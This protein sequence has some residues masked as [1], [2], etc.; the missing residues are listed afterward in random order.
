MNF[1]THKITLILTIIR[2]S[3]HN[4]IIKSNLNLY[5]FPEPCML[6]VAA[7]EL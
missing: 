4:D 3:L 1:I 6:S 5:E 7:D 2:V